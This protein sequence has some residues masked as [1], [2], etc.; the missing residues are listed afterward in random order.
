MAE[1]SLMRSTESGVLDAETMVRGVLRAIEHLGLAQPAVPSSVVLEKLPAAEEALALPP[2]S[3]APATTTPM[4]R[5]P[6]A[7]SAIG[8]GESAP[9]MEEDQA[10]HT[11]A[12]AEN[13]RLTVPEAAAPGISEREPHPSHT[14]A[15]WAVLERRL[16][17]EQAN[18][19]RIWA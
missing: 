15:R 3:T 7:A 4:L 8:H 9:T 13:R 12:S 18:S 10:G 17:A 6:K 1:I 5:R 14:V 16:E 19:R 11:A 2:P